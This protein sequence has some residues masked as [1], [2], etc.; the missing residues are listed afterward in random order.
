MNSGRDI[1]YIFNTQNLK[2]GDI[3]LMNTYHRS[4]QARMNSKY[5]H[6]ALY[7]GD[8]FILEADGLGATMNHIHS[9]GFYESDD[10]VVMRLKY[11]NECFINLILLSARTN[12]GMEYG[13]IGTYY[14]ELLNNRSNANKKIIS[15]DNRTFCFRF[16]AQAYAKVGIDIVSNPDYCTT[17]DFVH[18]EYLCEVENILTPAEDYLI[19]KVKKRQ[20]EREHD[21][22]LLPSLFEELRGIYEIDIQ[23]MDQFLMAA[24]KYPEKDDEAIQAFE[25]LRYFDFNYQTQR[26]HPWLLGN[27]MDFYNHYATTDDR[28]FFLLNQTLHYDKTYLPIFNQNAIIL[29]L[30]AEK[31]TSSKLIKYLSDGFNHILE[32]AKDI[33]DK[34]HEF[35]QFV[36]ERDK[37]SVDEFIGRFGSKL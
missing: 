28:L 4:I 14:R 11:W 30:Y 29:N 25:H 18:S 27:N 7:M 36:I 8:A 23:N 20:Y 10:V 5:D 37:Q 16:V 1:K 15:T 31:F 26:R 13:S 9:Y 35:T 3:L 32:C 12:M 21:E 33:R 19:E 17:D 34:L 22:A 24:I 2:K 6:A